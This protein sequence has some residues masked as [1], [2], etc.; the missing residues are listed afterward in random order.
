MGDAKTGTAN[1]EN[2]GVSVQADLDKL[3]TDRQNFAGRDWENWACLVQWQRCKLNDRSQL[4]DRELKTWWS[5]VEDDKGSILNLLH[6]VQ[7]GH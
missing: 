1:T 2:C 7:T 6:G 5:K 4:L 3:K